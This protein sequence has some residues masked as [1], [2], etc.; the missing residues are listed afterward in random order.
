MSSIAIIALSGRFPGGCD[1][2]EALWASLVDGRDLIEEV[3]ASRWN[4]QR[5]LRTEP[6]IGLDHLSRF[7]GFLR[8]IDLFDPVAFGISPR[9]AHTM[10]PAQRILLEEV[11][12]CWEGAG[13]SPASFAG[14]PVGV[15]IGAFTQD[16]LQLQL[17]GRA[18]TVSETHSATG[19]MQTLLSNRISYCFN[20]T[21]PSMTV[22]TACS[23][24]L[25][26]VHLA[27]SSITRGECELA[28]AGGAQLQLTPYHTAIEGRGGFLSPD[29]R[30]RAFDA[31]ANGYVRAEAAGM[32]MLAPLD[33]ALEQGWPVHGVIHASQVN[34]NGKGIG[35]T[36][37]NPQAQA[38][39][40]DSALAQAGLSPDAI[41]YVEAHGTGTRAGD[42]AEAQALSQSLGRGRTGNSLLIGSVKTNLGHAEAASGVVGMI[43]VLL[44]LRHQTI[45]PH[46]HW[47]SS[48]PDVDLE[49]CGLRLPLLA[50]PWPR[51][52]PYACVNSFGF[53][54]TNAHVI[55]GPPPQREAP[56][57]DG[58]VRAPH[59]TVLLSGA[60]AAHLPLQAAAM[61][62]FI[63][64]MPADADVGQLAAATIHQRHH[65]RHRL[66]L[67]AQDRAS[68][69][70]LLQE[71][72]GRPDS[73][74]WA[75]GEAR[76]PE[77][78]AVAWAFAGMGPQWA[79]MGRELSRGF[80]VFCEAFEQCMTRFARIAGFSLA[81]SLAQV[82]AG[83][84]P[85][86][87]AVLPTALAQ[88]LNL[89]FQI[90]L[91]ALLRTWG[92]RP[93]AVVGHSVGEIAAFHAAGALDLDTALT[94]VFHRSRL[95]ARLAG[96][97]GMISVSASEETWG[98]LLKKY[99][100][101]V[102]ARNGARM[103]TLAGHD[104]ALEALARDLA[105]Q[106]CYCRKLA[107]EVPYHSELMAPLEKEFR[108][109][110]Q[111]LRFQKVTTPLY[112]TVTGTRL[113][114]LALRDFSSYWWR[115]LREPV[116]FVDAI[117]QMAECGATV[118]QELSAQPVL[119]G[120]LRDIL[121]GSPASV[122][123]LRRGRDESAAAIESLARLYVH[124]VAVDWSALYAKPAHVVKQP[125]TVWHR[126]RYWSE[127]P[128]MRAQRLDQADH[129]FLGYRR[130]GVG[131]TWDVDLEDSDEWHLAD[132]RVQ[133]QARLPAAFFVE[134]VAAACKRIAPGSPVRLGEVR[135][136]RGVAFASNTR[137][138]LTTVADAASGTV[139]ISDDSGRPL[140]DAQLL[141]AWAVH[142]QCTSPLD[143]LAIAA[144][145]S[146]QRFYE[147]VRVLGY[148][149]G[150]GFRPLHSVEFDSKHCR[151]R[152][153]G[154]VIAGLDFA[155][156]ILDACLQS[157]LGFE[158]SD[159]S[160]GSG[161]SPHGCRLPVSI[162]EVRLHRAPGAD[163][164]PLVIEG[165]SLQ[166]DAQRSV[167]DL[168]LRSNTGEMLAELLSVV[169]KS[170]DTPSA[171]TAGRVPAET[172]FR[173]DW[174]NIE[175]AAAAQAADHYRP[176]RWLLWG[177]A[178]GHACSFARYLQSQ[179]E[180]VHLYDPSDPAESGW[181]AQKSEGDGSLLVV[182]L[183]ALDW[184]TDEGADLERIS[185][186]VTHLQRQCGLAGTHARIWLV[187][188][189]AQNA[190]APW[191]VQ[192]ALWGLVRTLG[193]VEYPGVFRGVADIPLEAGASWHQAL[194]EL[195][196]S[197]S[198]QNQFRLHEDVWQA[199]QLVACEPRADLP[200]P[201]LRGD[202]SY[203]ITG[204]FGALGRLTARFLIEA[205]AR[206]L[207]LLG[208][209]S[210]P[211]RADWSRPQPETWRDRIDWVLDLERKGARVLPL[212]FDIR[213]QHAWEG[214]EATV[215]HAGF[216]AIR[217][218]VHAAGMTADRAFAS[219]T[220]D[221]LHSVL[222][223]KISG[224]HRLLQ[225]NAG[226]DLDFL[227]LYSSISA[228]LPS[229]GQALYAA[230]NCYLDASASLLQQRGVPARSIAWGP[231]TI[232]MARGEKLARLFKAQGLVPIAPHEGYRILGNALSRHEEHLYCVAF[233]W[234]T[235]LETHRNQL[236]LLA[237]QLPRLEDVVRNRA[238]P[239][240]GDRATASG[241][242]RRDAALHD[243]I[244][245]AMEVMR[246]GES[247]LHAGSN[248]TQL[249]LDSLMAVEMQIKVAND[250]PGELGVIDLLGRGSLLDLADLLA[251]RSAPAPT[252]FP[253]ESQRDT[254]R[255]PA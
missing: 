205:G 36:L 177:S 155:P 55:L 19:A 88:P 31:G 124:G 233:D 29:G 212:G 247:D 172:L 45:P 252:N 133:G 188:R 25:V 127:S 38:G 129:P 238:S 126:S 156:E 228:L 50:Q 216:P 74:E 173:L 85:G 207:V 99:G 167:N 182:N 113:D 59:W 208:S 144:P 217:G 220:Q 213:S 95:Q 221:D 18:T 143:A 39:L 86:S 40:I 164:F 42:R 97:G 214:F 9:E 123:S 184:D 12:R 160:G 246:L 132:H 52:A 147:A 162:G 226:I 111:G 107:V 122:G 66:A 150:P 60:S 76:G 104:D 92:V 251:S 79:D 3:P 159:G 183:Q 121:Q 61:R 176:R 200:K 203:L 190:Q 11:W 112:S 93:C 91:S 224:L 166:R 145:W 140:V 229:H 102:A 196:R 114:D 80:P 72:L 63:D 106:G 198:R 8:D 192:A 168:K 47:Q 116:A 219:A 157:L 115:N 71:Y 187:T 181:E 240:R 108:E 24:S 174:R 96:Q 5:F 195:F 101:C 186:T 249:G 178:A 109:A 89:C 1:T 253:I 21:G 34:Q 243:L 222:G 4:V 185:K 215:R 90:A 64:A 77:L 152:I 218:I 151:A 41:G 204:G 35:V 230:A 103:V 139:R 211:P 83:N 2:P 250:W 70:G 231:W 17:G 241:A 202:A 119:Q 94:L 235:F 30:C 209:Q 225:A 15:F 69:S 189:G 68:L 154:K 125:G 100:V 245:Y 180:S 134:L 169:M 171:L 23:S 128:E 22:D 110:V 87:S 46:L 201:W 84:K 153:D 148:D 48:P 137:V 14:C 191:P 244:Q 28:F 20:F 242:E 105:H 120:Y 206:N 75:Q 27:A 163:D 13:I 10:D 7:G 32:L 98:P 56:T 149:Y 65:F 67:V 44:A 81:D 131:W 170:P 136:H 117:Q 248:L 73:T 130:P 37:P 33:R 49:G 237:D 53:G 234:P 51:E 43:K 78:G 16:Y 236:W 58:Q 232:G 158:L 175:S 118:F 6:A 161:G 141:T 199:P 239:R 26:A 62:D 194:F 135:F 223:P 197:A 165:N 254:D 193:N 227:L 57:T 138:R 82:D 255:I 54:G 142:A 146:A 179:G 210:P